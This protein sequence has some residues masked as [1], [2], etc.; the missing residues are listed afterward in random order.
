MGDDCPKIEDLGLQA[1]NNI[2]QHIL[3][4]FILSYNSYGGSSWTLHPLFVFSNF[5]LKS[6]L[7]NHKFVYCSVAVPSTQALWWQAWQTVPTSR[8]KPPQRLSFVFHLWHD[9]KH[10]PASHIIIKTAMPAVA[11]LHFNKRNVPFY[12]KYYNKMKIK[13]PVF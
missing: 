11:I 1:K 3:R 9:A 4:D 2:S 6:L 5:Y 10:H 12:Y 8:D 7:F 13:N